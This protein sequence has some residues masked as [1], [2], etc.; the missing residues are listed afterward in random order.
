MARLSEPWLV[1]AALGLVAWAVGLRGDRGWWRWA[2]VAVLTAALAFGAIGQSRLG[3]VEREWTTVR[4][5]VEQRAATAIAVALDELVDHGERAAD[6]AIALA[7]GLET[8]AGRGSAFARLEGLRRQSR[9]SALA[10]FGPDGNP[11]VWAG[12]HRGSVPAAIRHGEQAFV[13]HRGPLFGYLY[14]AEPLPGGRTAVAAVLLESSVP[15]GRDHTP[16]ADRFAA[17]H[18]VVPRFVAPDRAVGEAVWDWTADGPI[19]SVTF[20]RLTQEAWFARVAEGARWR[21]GAF[22]IVALLL[23]T[24]GWYRGSGRAPDVPVVVGALSLAIVPIGA[25][26]ELRG[27]FS[28]L[29]FVLPGPVDITLGQLLIVAVGLALWALVRAPAL[30]RLPRLPVWPRIALAALLV[31]GA[32]E[33]IRRAS[34]IGL[35]SARPAGGLALVLAATLLLAVLLFPL[36]RAPAAPRA[37]PPIPPLVAGVLLAGALALGV[38]LSWNPGASATLAMMALWAIPFALVVLAIRSL[39]GSWTTLA[40]W[41]LAGWLAGTASASFLWT[42]HLDARIDAASAELAQLGTEP[43][44]FL[45]YLL[46]QFAERAFAAAAEGEAGVNLLYRAWVTSGLAREGYEARLTSWLGDQPQAE[47]RFSDAELTDEIVTEMLPRARAAEEPL[48]ERYTAQENLH[49]LLLIPLPDDRVISVATPPRRRLGRA[50]ALARFLH[51]EE[52][53]LAG[54]EYDRLSL[55]PAPPPPPGAAALR[56]PGVTW[57]RTRQGWRSETDVPFPMGAMHAHLQVVAPSGWVLTIRGLL[58]QV[59][60]VGILLALWAAARGLRGAVP[61]FGAARWTW[62]RT[63]RGRLTLAL[64]GFFLIPTLVLGAVAYGA[65]SQQVQRTGSALALR[66]LELAAPDVAM[67][68]LDVLG[69]RVRTDLL[70]YRDGGLAGA[71]AP[72][73]IDL[74]LFQSWLPRS[75]ELAFATGEEIESLEEQR[76]AGNRY[77][78]AYRRI[79][80][81]GVLA[82]PVPLASGEIARMQREFAHGFLLMMV[83]GAALSVVLALMVGRALSHPMERLAR[84]TAAV[85]AGNLRVRLPEQRVD[86]FGPVYRAFN[87]MVR[88]LRRARA[89]EVRTARVL[90]W[91]E[92]ARQVAHEIKN[93][94]TPIKLS[95]QHLRRAHQDGRPDF[96]RILD[97]NVEAIL[98]EIDRLGSIARAF[99]R[100]G[101]PRAEPGTLEPVEIGRVIDETLVLYRGGKDDVHYRVSVAP[102]VHTVTAREGELREVLLNLLE[103]AREAVDAGGVVA[104][105]V[106][107]SGAGEWVLL[108]VRDDGVGI[109]A[110]QLHRIF[111]PQFSTRTS[112]T[113]LGLAIVRRLVESWGGEISASSQPGEG[114]TLH[115]R[116]RVGPEPAGRGVDGEGARP[117]EAVEVE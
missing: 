70:L 83:L 63:F 36:L 65:F 91:G 114:T 116:L 107:P 80:D 18:G 43:D 74:G 71:S 46:R 62:I 47:L 89:D 45:D 1:L 111:E 67:E 40:A 100:F 2:T 3:G 33:I 61:G 68:P 51:A 103:N 87:R 41:L 86:E 102:G 96:D 10:V 19:F 20:A 35:F 72:E 56:E 25:M 93:P 11:I 113:G 26:V 34:S 98:R 6:G 84:A 42:Q 54:A 79:G 115:M 32:L 27:L 55:V 17:E 12:Q 112:G 57:V 44:P 8:A 29:L 59:L 7:P 23:L 24:L 76:L 101:A 9:M 22:W 13:F 88:R 108:D 90:A 104:I 97:R 81:E 64:F 117:G 94:L 5:G 106:A 99:A 66:S 78:V 85:G 49:Y 38:V 53:T 60:T 21:A 105:R 28:P 15:V 39:P 37:K 95:V 77:L 16:F 4:A 31:P 30:A 110:D 14:F 73:V 92:M 109:P 52:P 82:A 69:D 48:L 75:V 50:T 58:V